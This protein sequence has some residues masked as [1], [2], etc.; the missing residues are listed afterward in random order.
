MN[1]EQLVLFGDIRQQTDEFGHD[2]I[3]RLLIPEQ[4]EALLVVEVGVDGVRAEVDRQR[5]EA[6]Q[7]VADVAVLREFS[8][9]VRKEIV[10]ALTKVCYLDVLG[11]V[12]RREERLGR[13]RCAVTRRRSREARRWTPCWLSIEAWWWGGSFRARSQFAV[14]RQHSVHS[15]TELCQTRREDGL[16]FCRLFRFWP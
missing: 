8:R 2:V 14:L 9:D 5:L 12:A 16:G 15:L 3:E 11:L 10:V 7:T 1:I 13:I 6:R 4:T